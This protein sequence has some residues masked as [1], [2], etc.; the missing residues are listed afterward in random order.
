MLQ[1]RYKV[2]APIEHRDGGHHW[3]RLGNGFP[4][5]DG[6]INMY[7][8]LLPL[9]G[10]NGEIT[11]QLREL[12]DEELRERSDKRATYQSRSPGTSHL[13]TTSMTPAA[14]GTDALPF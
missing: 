5:K 1:K 3:A 12:T 9:A 6:S 7:L 8:T 14:G 10:K 4:N 11:L 2:I 13:T